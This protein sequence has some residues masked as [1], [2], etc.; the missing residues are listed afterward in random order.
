MTRLIVLNDNTPSVGLLN[1]WGWSVLVEGRHRF[2]FDADTNPLV[3]ANNS[4]VLGVSLRDL[5]FGFLSHWHRDHY[6]GF[7]YIAELN[8]GL[9]LYSPPGNFA[10]AIRWGLRPVTPEKGHIMD[11][12]WT[13][14]VIDGFEHALGIETPSGLVVIVGCS[15]PG[16]E[17][18]TREILDASGH[19]R[20]HIVI[21][22]FHYPS[23]SSLDKVA[24]MSELIAPA[25]CSGDTAKAYVQKNYPEKFVAVRTGSMLEF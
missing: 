24:E 14:G 16:V 17:R 2:I 3:L 8:P 7:Q 1:E 9:K 12:L 22:G 19:R 13:S 21:G 20:A 10:M 5:E 11:D 25:H 23:I 15:H 18:L 6:G 4:K